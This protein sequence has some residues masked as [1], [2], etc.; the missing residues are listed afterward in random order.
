MLQVLTSTEN[1]VSHGTSRQRPI[2]GQVSTTYVPELVDALTW[3]TALADFA[4]VSYEQSDCYMSGQWGGRV[5]RL[6]VREPK[7]GCAVGGAL[8]VEITPPLLSTGLAY[9]KFGPFWQRRCEQPNEE[10]FKA[11]VNALRQEFCINRGHMLSILPRP[12]PDVEVTETQLL[13]DMGFC[14][15]RSFDDPDRYLV[16]I[17]SDDDTQMKSL[18]QKWRY[19]LK[20]AIKNNITVKSSDD[21]AGLATFKTLHDEM[22][23]RKKFND[24]DAI[25]LIPQLRS[26]LPDGLRPHVF[27]AYH[28][29]KPVSGAVVGVLGNTAYYV[30]GASSDDALPLKAGYAMQWEIL[31][32]LQGRG[33][34]WYDLGGK[35]AE[36][37]LHQFKKGLV[38]KTGEIWTMTGEMDCWNGLGGRLLGDTL[39]LMRGIMQKLHGAIH[40]IAG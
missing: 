16:R 31:R 3:D 23:A 34:N 32:W 40:R 17:H 14:Q 33:A 4:D 13:R 26:Q 15:R 37:G 30:Y 18:A 9:V 1:I 24:V 5:S 7:N 35:V 21:A 39:Y 22:V 29:D 2:S 27:I 19:N 10:V 25:D 36:T 8:V 28:N 38:G 12:S 20:K 11:I 6:L